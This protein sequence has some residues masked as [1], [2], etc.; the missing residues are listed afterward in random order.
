MRYGGNR[1]LRRGFAP[2]TVMM[3]MDRYHNFYEG[4]IIIIIFIFIIQATL[5]MV[6]P[7]IVVTVCVVLPSAVYSS[8]AGPSGNFV[9]VF[10][11]L[12]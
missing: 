1:W 6:L 8:Q 7:S 12:N 2:R 4:Y 10:L 3:V 9:F 11:K 5:T